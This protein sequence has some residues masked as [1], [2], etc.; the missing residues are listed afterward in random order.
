MFANRA[1][2]IAVRPKLTAPQ[3]FLHLRTTTKNLSRRQA[4]HHPHDLCHA[5]GRHRLNQKMDVI[6]IRAYL[7]KLHLVTLRNPHTPL[8]ELHQSAR[9]IPR[10]CTSPEIP[11]GTSTPLHCG[12]S[13]SSHKVYA[14]S[15][16]ELNP[17]RLNGRHFLFGDFALPDDLFACALGTQASPIT[18]SY[19]NASTGFNPAARFAVSAAI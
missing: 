17:K 4:F 14:S 2:K 8:S 12:Y 3:L 16:V 11:S 15:G 7:Q 9:R 13:R 6:F 10:V 18:H 5:V 19:R 1:R